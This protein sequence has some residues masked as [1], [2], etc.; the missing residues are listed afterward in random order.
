MDIDALAPK[1]FIVIPHRKGEGFNTNLSLS[2][3]WWAK[4]NINIQTL[5]DAFGGFIEFTRQDMVNSFLDWCEAHPETEYLI[6]IDSD[7]EV[8]PEAPFQLAAHGKDIISGIYPGYDKER[9]VFATI[10]VEDENGVPRFPLLR[11]GPLPASGIKKVHSCA[12]GLLCIHKRVLE[13]FRDEGIYPFAMP[14][15][16]R[17]AS[18]AIGEPILGEDLIFCERAKEAGFDIWV[19]FGVRAGHQKVIDLHWT[20]LADINPDDYQTTEADHGHPTG[21]RLWQQTEKM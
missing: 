15:N 14:D 20:N 10:Q 6:M 2:I 13:H 8:P 12:T 18:L 1:I 7:E 11:N 3:G 16:M 21:I 5:E 17:K 4:F 9:G 19:D